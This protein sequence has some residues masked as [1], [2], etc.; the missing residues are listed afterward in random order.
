MRRRFRNQ[1]G[2]ALLETAITIPLILLISVAIF[3]FGRAFQ[4]WQVLTNAAR[5][6]ARLAVITG[7][8]DEQI[9]TRVRDY[10]DGGGLALA[11]STD[12]DV[13]V[14]RDVPFGQSNASQIT[15]R[16]PFNFMVLNPVVR[17]VVPGSTTGAGPL[18]MGASALMRNEN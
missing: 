1:R 13:E 8:T 3:E 17:L 15:I 2:A 5:E 9:T 18:P 16:Y 7:T 4:T 11:R 10:L 6:G 12:V 14:L